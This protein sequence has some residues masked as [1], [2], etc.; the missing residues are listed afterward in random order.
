MWGW[1]GTIWLRK[2]L[3][4]TRQSLN[5]L[6]RFCSNSSTSTLYFLCCCLHIFSSSNLQ[7]FHARYTLSYYTLTI[8]HS[9]LLPYSPAVL[10]ILM[11]VSVTT[12]LL[13]GKIW[14]KISF[15]IQTNEY[16]GSECSIESWPTLSMKFVGINTKEASIWTNNLFMLHY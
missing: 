13:I 9:Y 5:L 6:P 10:F 8:F 15:S 2:S 3:S 1:V 14:T 4:N 12:H 7:L 11:S 16:S